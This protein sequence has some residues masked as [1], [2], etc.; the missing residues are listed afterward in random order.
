M[1][2]G[3]EEMAKIIGSHL[4]KAGVLPMT[5][6]AMVRMALIHRDMTK[7]LS[8]TR[9]QDQKM[10]ILGN[11]T[12]MILNLLLVQLF[13]SAEASGLEAGRMNSVLI[14]VMLNKAATGCLLSAATE[15]EARS[16]FMSLQRIAFDRTVEITDLFK[17]QI[18]SLEREKKSVSIH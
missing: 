8:E 5:A 18:E 11:C 9:D 17:E 13:H 14:G 16:L 3:D 2:Q 6:S 1:T 12:E 7:K 4:V 10:N 15:D